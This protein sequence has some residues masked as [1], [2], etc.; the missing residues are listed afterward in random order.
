M[1]LT[2]TTLVC[3]NLVTVAH[4][5]WSDITTY[6][7][8]MSL[9]RKMAINRQEVSQNWF[10]YQFWTAHN[11]RHSLA[12]LVRLQMKHMRWLFNDADGFGWSWRL[13]FL[14]LWLP[15]FAIAFHLE[16]KIEACWVAFAA[17]Q[18]ACPVTGLYAQQL[19]DRSF[20]DHD[21]SA[22]HVFE[23]F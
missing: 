12:Q 8:Q 20:C 9:Y 23:T 13:S 16:L 22:A 2:T 5:C 19:V 11:T 17:V 4:C 14:T 3:S 15:A 7:C 1:L 18:S 6:D 21:H 10:W